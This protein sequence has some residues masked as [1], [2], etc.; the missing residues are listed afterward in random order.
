MSL[1]SLILAG[2]LSLGLSAPQALSAPIDWTYY[3]DPIFGY[4]VELPLGLFTPEREEAGTLTLLEDGGDGQI[5][6]YAGVN[7][8]GMSIADYEDA[9]SRGQQVEAVTYRTGG[10]SWFVLSGFFRPDERDE[11]PLIFYTKFMLSRDGERFSAFEISF[12]QSDKP[13]LAPI[14]ERIEDSF[15]RPL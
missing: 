1:R 12:P 15:T 10:R 13:R 5:N 7:E 8:D 4:G 14:V 2:V 3:E 9:L 11:E 6:I